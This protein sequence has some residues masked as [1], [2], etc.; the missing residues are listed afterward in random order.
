MLLL[1]PQ[2]LLLP[3]FSLLP[4][5]TPFANFAAGGVPA[6]PVFWLCLA[7]PVIAASLLVLLASLSVLAFLLLLASLSLLAILLWLKAG[8][9]FCCRHM[10]AASLLYVNL[11]SV[12]KDLKNKNTI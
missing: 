12:L 2:L 4:N 6:I 10:L 9:P 5:L 8:A 11:M 1:F 3:T 7:F